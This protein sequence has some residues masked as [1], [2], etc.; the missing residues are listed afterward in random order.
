M[1]TPADIG[2]P[3]STPLHRRIR[4]ARRAK[5][6]SQTEVAN[7]VGCLQSQVSMIESGLPSRV[8][9]E[10]L[11]KV[12]DFLGVEMEGQPAIAASAAPVPFGRAYC[13]QADCPSNLP[14]VAG[15]DLFFWP[16][17]QPGA[18]RPGHRCVWCGEVLAFV[19]PHCGAPAGNGACCRECGR[20]YVAPP[21]VLDG[22]PAEWAVRRRAEI[23][24][25]RNFR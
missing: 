14:Y 22:D 8:A 25:L 17:A 2:L 16:A 21:P 19:C 12:A 10:T 23:E 4:D 3:A 15:G 7:R 13:P 11:V 20:P 1:D 6:L 18:P 24:A 9:R 5:G